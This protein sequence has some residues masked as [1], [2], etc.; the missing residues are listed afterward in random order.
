MT[1]IHIRLVPINYGEAGSE[2]GRWFADSGQDVSTIV[3]YLDGIYDMEKSELTCE[4]FVFD[5]DGKKVIEK[6]RHA[7][8][9]DDEGPIYKKKD[10]TL[11]MR[12]VGAYGVL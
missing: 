11:K 9:D 6:S 2:L 5:K 10:V 1:Q 12:P 8:E 7:D 3:A 4:A